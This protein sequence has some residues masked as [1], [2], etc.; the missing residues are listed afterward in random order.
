MRGPAVL[1]PLQQPQEAAHLPPVRGGGAVGRGGPAAD[2]PR[3]SDRPRPPAGAQGLARWAGTPEPL[4]GSRRGPRACSGALRRGA[5]GVTGG[6]VPPWPA[7]ARGETV[8][9]AEQ[10][11]EGASGRSRAEGSG[12]GRPSPGRAPQPLAPSAVL[13]P[14]APGTWSC[15]RVHLGA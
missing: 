4:P 2:T 15:S 11:A 5:G 8:G 3:P 1:Q 9:E 14:V 12:V 7:S 10:P 13:V 6:P